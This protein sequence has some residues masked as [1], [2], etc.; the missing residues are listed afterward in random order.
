VDDAQEN[1]E[2][3]VK[4]GGYLVNYVRLSD[5]QAMVAGLQW[6][7]MVAELQRITDAMNKTTEEST[8]RKQK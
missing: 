8:S 6:I 1:I 2:D 5:N 4:V 7:I 3:G